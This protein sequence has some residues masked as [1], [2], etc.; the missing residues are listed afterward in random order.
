MTVGRDTFIG[1]GATIVNG[2]SI[3]GGV[4]I[5]AGAVV[6]RDVTEPGTYAGVPAKRIG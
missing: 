6:V 5:G 3:C 2:V 1:A 4:I